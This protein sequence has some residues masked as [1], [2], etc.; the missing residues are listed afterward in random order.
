MIMR[1]SNGAAQVYASYGA[2]Y[3]GR[4]VQQ[5]IK[6]DGGAGD[7]QERALPMLGIWSTLLEVR[8]RAEP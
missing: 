2:R 6:A 7:Y 8:A 1:Q 4:I 3:E 5:L